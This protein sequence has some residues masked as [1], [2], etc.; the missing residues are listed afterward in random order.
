ML[1]VVI[2]E[3]EDIIRKGLV[4]T[5][6]WQSM[7]ACVV[8]EAAD[9]EQGLQVVREQQPDVVLTDIRMPRLDWQN[10]AEVVKQGGSIMVCIFSGMGVGFGAAILAGVTG[11]ALV[12]PIVT[13]LLL[14]LTIWMWRSL[15]K[16]GERRLLLLH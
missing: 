8:G 10:E 7:G 9:G 4:C 13:V 5:V 3:D 14:I 1:K 15:V 11:S 2:V 6:D 12:Q 16:S